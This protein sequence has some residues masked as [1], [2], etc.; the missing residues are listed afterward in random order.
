MPRKSQDL[1]QTLSPSEAET[2]AKDWVELFFVRSNPQAE[3]DAASSMAQ[4]VGRM[5]DV[6]AALLIAGRAI[7]LGGL[8]HWVGRLTASTLDLEP[9]DGRRM[10]PILAGLLRR[11]DALEHVCAPDGRRD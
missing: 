8:D 11:L 7:D 5:L 9:A 3:F 2:P 4:S 1:D 6:S 10:R